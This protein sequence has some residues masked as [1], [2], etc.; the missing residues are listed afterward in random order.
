MIQFT[1][2][3]WLYARNIKFKYVVTV[4]AGFAVYVL[5]GDVTS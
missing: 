2:S 4:S 5:Y 1:G 3:L